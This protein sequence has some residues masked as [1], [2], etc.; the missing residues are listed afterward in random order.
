M[1][2]IRDIVDEA[3]ASRHL[4][5]AAERQLRQ[6]LKTPYT[7]DELKAFLTLQ[8]G[9][10]VGFIKQESREVRDRRFAATRQPENISSN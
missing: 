2:S 1:T 9:I 7:S 6:S 10:M 3:I 5:I 4:S 8:Q